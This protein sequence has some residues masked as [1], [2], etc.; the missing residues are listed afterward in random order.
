MGQPHIGLKD[1]I[2]S[3]L[4][5]LISFEGN[6]SLGE[7]DGS[8]TE[9]LEIMIALAVKSLNEGKYY[10][11]IEL[12]DE[13][14]TQDNINEH[15]FACLSLLNIHLDNFKAAQ[16]Y[17]NQAAT[18]HNFLGD[19]SSACDYEKAQKTLSD[20]EQVQKTLTELGHCKPAEKWESQYAE[21]HPDIKIFDDQ[22]S[23]SP[24]FLQHLNCELIIHRGCLNN[25]LENSIDG[26]NEIIAV[27]PDVR[28]EI[29]ITMTSDNVL[30]L[31]H[32][33]TLSRLKGANI[34]VIA[35][36]YDEIKRISP[37]T[38]LVEILDTF[39]DQ[40]FV[41][42]IKHDFEI[43]NSKS[44]IWHGSP[45][46]F[47]P[48][49]VIQPLLDALTGRSSD[50]LLLTAFS[51]EFQFLLE[52][53]FPTFDVVLVDGRAQAAYKSLLESDLPDTLSNYPTWLLVDGPTL[54][55]SLA[56]ALKA[57]GHKILTGPSAL[58]LSEQVTQAAILDLDA[59]M[60]SCM[61]A[62][63]EATMFRSN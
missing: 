55:A 15:A 29:D 10:A 45:S 51:R 35:A 43:E 7:T 21:I 22:G 4:N 1:K 20:Y 27:A 60:I 31:N 54:D 56:T 24:N 28:I 26:I 47:S 49:K 25:E 48:E 18:L 62:D 19:G 13:V 8:A 63:L 42:D 50:K 34:P 61:T 12:F 38:T 9:P 30:I 6:Q 36:S 44:A 23:F 59:I 3:Q 5:S 16:S 40:K 53:H 37:A 32:D 46:I 39:P 14:I 2:I 58:S 57:H 33:T 17:L 41:I 11:A 52:Q